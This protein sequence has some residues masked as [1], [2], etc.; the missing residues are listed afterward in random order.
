MPAA[1]HYTRSVS[2]C[3]NFV[4]DF[5]M[6]LEAAGAALLFW[7]RRRLVWDSAHGPKKLMRRVVQLSD[8]M[9]KHLNEP[10]YDKSGN[11]CA[12]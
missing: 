1:V 4:A 12:L 10:S 9:T 7:A 3:V 5:V 2:E 8:K 11:M 6:A